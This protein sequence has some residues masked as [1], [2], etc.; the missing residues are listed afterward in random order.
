MQKLN[1]K[2][3]Q[4]WCKVYFILF[5][6]RI[7]TLFMTP[8]EQKYLASFANYYL[9]RHNHRPV[10]VIAMYGKFVD[11]PHKITSKLT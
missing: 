1:S 4:N 3:L 8:L 6:T 11:P 10:I 2:N 7:F 5:V 9:E